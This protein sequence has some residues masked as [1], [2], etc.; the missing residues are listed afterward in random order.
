MKIEI[1]YIIGAVQALFFSGLAIN[2][3]K[4]SLGDYVMVAWFVLLAILLFSYSLEVMAIEEQYPIFWSLTTGLSLLIGPITLMYVLAYTQRNQHIHLLHALHALPYIVFTII[5]CLKMTN[6]SELSVREGIN[7]IED[8]REPTFAVFELFRI[9]QG[10]VYLIIS[11]IVLKK[12]NIRI[13]G[14]FSYTENIDLKWVRNVILMLT[15]IWVTVVVVNVL[16]NFNQFFSWQTGDNLIY[17]VVT[18]TVFVNGYYGIK[19]QLIFSPAI[20]T[21]RLHDKQSKSQYIKSSLSDKESKAYLQALIQYM[22]EEKPYLDGKLSLAQVAAHLGITTNHLSQVINGELEK[23]FFD[24]INT[25]RV[26][27][28]KEKIIDPSNSHLTLLALALESGFNSKSSFN[29]IFKKHTGYTPSQFILSQ[30]S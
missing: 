5:I 22:E 3:R 20:A 4:K 23:N 24:F 12:H 21:I 18:I 2:K 15:L 11:L 16:T 30:R 10:P 6:L 19:Q 8:G 14:Q 29:N 25:Y 7:L 27:I 1:V 28:V 13:G 9:F 26:R 17:I